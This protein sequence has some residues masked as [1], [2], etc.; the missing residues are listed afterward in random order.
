MGVLDETTSKNK[1][2]KSESSSALKLTDEIL[3][4]R[5]IDSKWAL[6]KTWFRMC[7]SMYCC[8]KAGKW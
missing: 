4:F 6:A 3:M 7:Q 1:V 2:E 5:V 8:G